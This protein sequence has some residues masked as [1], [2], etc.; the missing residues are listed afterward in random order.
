MITPKPTHATELGTTILSGINAH[1][2]LVDPASVS[3]EE[4]ARLAAGGNDRIA[5][6]EALRELLVVAESFGWPNQLA[7][8]TREEFVVRRGA[9]LDEVVVRVERERGKM[10]ASDG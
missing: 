1:R 5:G 8:E 3:A 2:Y 4:N 6:K 9:E 10:V 7:T